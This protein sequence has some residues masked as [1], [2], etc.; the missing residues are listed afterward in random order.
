MTAVSGRLRSISGRVP[1]HLRLTAGVFGADRRRGSSTRCSTRSPIS[2]RRCATSRLRWSTSTE[3]PAA[4]SCAT[5]RC[6][7]RRRHRD[8]AA[9][10]P[11]RAAECLRTDG[12]RHPRRSRSISSATC[13][14][15]ALPDRALCR[16]QLFPDLPTGVAGRGRGRSDVR[17]GDRD[18]PPDRVRDRSRG[19][20]R[21][22]RSAALTAVPLFNPQGGYADL[23]LPAAF[24]LILQ[25]TLL[26]GVGLLG[27]LPAGIP[28]GQADRAG[29]YRPRSRQ[30]ACLSRAA[31]RYPAGLFVVLPYVYGIPRLGSIAAILLFAIPFILSVGAL[32]MVVAAISAR[33]LACNWRWRRS[34]YRSSCWPASPGRSRPS[35]PPSGCFDAGAEHVGNR[36]VREDQPARCAALGRHS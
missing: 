5:C 14:T 19:G 9:G 11:E 28:G 22:R 29:S 32:G 10:C 7:A 25:Q 17:H 12:F 8:G 13:C 27:T 18:C 24:V 3:R 31:D 2:T 34:P 30:V 20:R 26:I 33:R 4:A 35:R 1:P 36:R 16:R 21:G 23:Y 6:D 15:A